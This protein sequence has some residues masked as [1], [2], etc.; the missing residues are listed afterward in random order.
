MRFPTLFRLPRHQQFQIEAR[1][2]DPVKEELE[3]R[4]EKIK[5]ELEGKEGKKIVPSKITF[6]KKK[7]PSFSASFIQLG[8][9]LL[10]GLSLLGWLQFGNTVFYYLLWLLLAGYLFYRLKR[11]R[12]R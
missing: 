1:Y 8:L 3:G 12:R 9:A 6:K 11:L 7:S 2:Y 10:L 4:T 5:A